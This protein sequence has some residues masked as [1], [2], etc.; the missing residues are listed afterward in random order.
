MLASE[1][2]EPECT[3]SVERKLVKAWERARFRAGAEGVLR[4]MAA[5]ENQRARGIFVPLAEEPAQSGVTERIELAIHLM[6]RPNKH[7]CM[8]AWV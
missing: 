3:A 7:F 4:G 1:A 2:L 6:V 8:R 5:R